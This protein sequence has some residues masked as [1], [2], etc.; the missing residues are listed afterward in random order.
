MANIE[1]VV[2]D[3]ADK[4]IKAVDVYG[5]KATSLVLETGRIAA[6]QELATGFTFAAVALI[7]LSAAGVCLSKFLKAERYENEG[8]AASIFA[9]VG[10]FLVTALGAFTFLLNILAWVG[11]HHPEIYLAAKLLKL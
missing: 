7:A 3:A 5:P 9:C 1:Q 8:W 6:M 11:L 10:I 2:V 4:L